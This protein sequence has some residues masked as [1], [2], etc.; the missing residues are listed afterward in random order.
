MKKN[1]EPQRYD[2]PSMLDTSFLE[3]IKKLIAVLNTLYEKGVIP[4]MFHIFETY[5]TPARQKWLKDQKPARTRADPWKSPHNYGK[6][7]DLVPLVNGSLTWD[8]SSEHWD[9]LKREAEKLGL[10][11]GLSWDRAHVEDKDW[12]K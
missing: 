8:V 6:A 11:N 7:V 4:F 2:D 10:S 3:K 1:L 5:R 12:K 9:V